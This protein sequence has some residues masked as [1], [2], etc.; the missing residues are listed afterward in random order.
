MT[1]LCQFSSK[2]SSIK[3]KTSLPSDLYWVLT[4]IAQNY[5]SG[6][7]DGVGVGVGQEGLETRLFVHVS[8]RASTTQSQQASTGPVFLGWGPGLTR[9][10]YGIVLAGVPSSSQGPDHCQLE[11]QQGPAS[12]GI[13]QRSLHERTCVRPVP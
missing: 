10:G 12:A 1:N 13:T 11:A 5:A 4:V 2:P 7:C 9:A 6:S 8:H 3:K